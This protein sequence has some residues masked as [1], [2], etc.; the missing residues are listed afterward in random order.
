LEGATS[1]QTVA[2]DTLM[3][4]RIETIATTKLQAINK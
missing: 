4:M 2:A 1:D 3:L